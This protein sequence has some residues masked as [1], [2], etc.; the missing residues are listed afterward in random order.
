MKGVRK[1]TE[2]KTA[3]A[4][5]LVVEDD[6]A[7]REAAVWVLKLYGFDAREAADGPAALKVL[8]ENPDIDLVFSDVVMPKGMSGLDLAQ[9]ILDR[10]PGMKVLLTTGYADL[11]VER[12]TL[13]ESGIRLISK[14]YANEEF[15][16]TLHEMLGLPR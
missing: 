11:A 6:A 13:N 14:P 7:V 5:I 16:N 15:V 3:M 1:A 9:Q 12:A 10:R 8:D 4:T 2:P